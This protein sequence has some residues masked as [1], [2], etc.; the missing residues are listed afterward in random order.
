MIKINWMKAKLLAA[1][2]TVLNNKKPASREEMLQ[3]REKKLRRLLR[4]AYAHSPYY[5]ESFSKA[6]ITEQNIDTMPLTAFP[7]IDK[8]AF[9]D[10]YEEILTVQPFSQKELRQFDESGESG[11]FRNQYHVVHS[12]GST[13]TPKYFVYNKKEWMQVQTR[14]V[15]AASIGLSQE[16]LAVDLED[17]RVL[18]IAATGGRFGG[19]M[20]V[21]AASKLFGAQLQ[22]LD[23]NEPLSAWSAVLRTYRPNV[24]VGYSTALK[25]LADLMNGDGIT[26][27][28]RR[29]VSCG[30][31]LTPDVRAYLERTF[32]QN[33]I[34]CYA[35]TESLALGVEPDARE[36]MLL[37]DDLNY[38]EFV[39]GQLY[40]TNLYNYSQPLIRYAISD[41]MRL[42]DNCG[43]YSAYT[44]VVLM[45]GRLDD[46]L[47]FTDPIGKKEFLHP[48]ILE[49]FSFPGLKDYQ[50]R[51]I[52][53]NR[54]EVL[55]ET[56]EDADTAGVCA[57]LRQAIDD[58]LAKNQLSF[59][60]YRL[61]TDEPIL[62]DP[63]TGKKRL[64]IQAG[65]RS[66]ADTNIDT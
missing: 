5:R 22:V 45:H 55:V 2:L 44:H 47:W 36:G 51:Q 28:V 61:I 35:A 29:V 59:L 41:R 48:T 42:A 19:M 13:G 10:H 54:F 6:G 20:V 38:L 18:Y 14:I 49:D 43:T 39:D 26:L 23:V 58:V 60:S 37:Y 8:T 31:S 27:D 63:V 3:L 46:I 34:N 52:S 40:L 64:T 57:L 53:N 1:V 56:Q 62:A 11:L 15:Q 50:F 16:E 4:Y 12:S 24:I 30:E 65:S 25:M 32:Q 66:G 17:L 33:V 21:S 9:M 7:T